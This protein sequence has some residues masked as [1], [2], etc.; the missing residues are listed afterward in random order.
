MPVDRAANV[1]QQHLR[2]L[3]GLSAS[4]RTKGLAHTYVSDI[5]G[6]ARVSRRTFYEH[7]QDK[8]SCLVE[9][10]RAST[11]H[12]IETISAAI[13][14]DASRAV[15]IEQTIDAYLWTLSRE[16]TLALALAGSSAGD[17][18]WRAQQEG[19]VRFAEF[20]LTL[21]D[22]PV[23]GHAPP[24]G[25]SMECA[26]MLASRLCAA[27]LYAIERAEGLDRVGKEVKEVLEPVLDRN[28]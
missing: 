27:A 14:L 21:T 2:L 10:V 4:I 24:A 12:L 3:D 11:S 15:E 26:Y 20:L 18:V 9:L 1:E 6:H 25:I 7:F 23:P 5:V 19:L 28:A 8:D 22:R 16:P 13:D 17:A